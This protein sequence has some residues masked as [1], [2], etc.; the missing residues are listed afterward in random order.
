M[1]AVRQ[2]RVHSVCFFL[3]KTLEKADYGTE[4][5]SWFPEG[6]GSIRNLRTLRGMDGGGY[7]YYLEY[8][9]FSSVYTCSRT[10]CI[11]YVTCMFIPQ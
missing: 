10:Y 1:Q 11:F 7:V 4:A 8:A 5:G 3:F 9:G 2:K 6:G